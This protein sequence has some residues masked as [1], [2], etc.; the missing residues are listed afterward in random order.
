MFSRLFNYARNNFVVGLTFWY[1]FI[2]VISFILLFII[3]Y[4]FISESI[5]QN[6]RQDISIESNEL[7]LKYKEGGIDALKKELDFEILVSGSNLYF[8][9]VANDQNKTVFINIPDRSSEKY[10]NKISSIPVSTNSHWIELSG[11][12]D[13]HHWEILSSVLGEGYILQVGKST[14]LRHGFL[15]RFSGIIT[16]VVIIMIAVGFTGGAI[17]A[18]RAIRPVRTL[19]S[20]LK[21]KYVI[22]GNEPLIPA[23]GPGNEFDE[24]AAMYK[25]ILNKNELLINELRNALDNIAHDIRTPITRLKGL[26]ELAVHSEP[27]TKTL[28]E[29]L[30]KCIEESELITTILNTLIGITAVE[31]GAMKLEIEKSNITE[32]IG[33]VVEMYSFVAEEKNITITTKLPG[34]LTAGVDCN[35]M[36]QLLANIVDNA[37]KYTQNGGKVEI[38]AY[39]RKDEIVINIKDSG[40]GIP[41]MKY[42]RFGTASTAGIKAARKRDSAWD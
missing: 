14:E 18:R 3:S 11:N 32:L 36:R 29:A 26:A 21:S 15:N 20:E 28:K 37:I 5:K 13:S 12:D 1:T 2:F 40:A 35:K 27:D 17:I 34:G 33:Q 38:E 22:A 24:L 25:S 31:S 10:F 7:E 6:D 19:L 8:V 30:N 9:R 23:K 16:W 39:E 4:I 41:R 42:R